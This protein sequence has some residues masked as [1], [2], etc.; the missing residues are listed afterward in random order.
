MDH[1]V[2]HP[3]YVHLE[4]RIIVHYPPRARAYL[5]NRFSFTQGVSHFLRSAW[6]LF[7]TAT[8]LHEKSFR[9]FQVAASS[10][11]AVFFFL[12][13]LFLLFFLSLSRVQAQFPRTARSIGYIL[14]VVLF[15]FSNFISADMT[16]TII[17]SE[18]A[19][20]LNRTLLLHKLGLQFD[21][22]YVYY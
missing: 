13:L 19:K 22:P 18:G 15:S 9:N 1:G 2:S 11:V 8:S 14:R 17:V 12:F 21:L 3:W 16:S 10:R 5:A 20:R 4:F 6:P 7:F